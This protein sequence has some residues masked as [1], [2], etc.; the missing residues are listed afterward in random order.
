MAE[1][2]VIAAEIG[3]DRGEEETGPATADEG[4]IGYGGG[5]DTREAIDEDVIWEG[6][7]IGREAVVLFLYLTASNHS[8]KSTKPSSNNPL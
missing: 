1:K 4:E 2:V 8:P 5:W 6:R 7:D 3:E